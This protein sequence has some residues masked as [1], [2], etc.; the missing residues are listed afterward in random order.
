[1]FF[2]PYHKFTLSTPLTTVEVIAAMNEQVGPTI[3]TDLMGRGRGDFDPF[4][5]V[6][7]MIYPYNGVVYEDYFAIS[8]S[9]RGFPMPVI[10]GTVF[11]RERQ[12]Y[13]Y[14]VI[15]PEMSQQFIVLFLFL[16]IFLLVCAGSIISM[17]INGFDPKMLA[18]TG[19]FIIPYSLLLILFRNEQNITRSFLTEVLKGKVI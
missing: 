19:T 7:E 12:T 8:R 16:G 10:W 11:E 1:M 17:L 13:V 5:E 2:L 3:S 4:A 15:K 18:G 14:V 6:E 9:V